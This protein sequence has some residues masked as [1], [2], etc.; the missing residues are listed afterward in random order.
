MII[1]AIPILTIDVFGSLL[2][3]VISLFALHKAKMLRK[4]DPLNF[5]YLYLVWICVGFV[6]FAVSRSSGHVLKQMLGL[7]HSHSDWVKICP[8]TGTINTVT[9]MLVGMITLFLSRAGISTSGSAT[10]AK[11]LKML[12]QSFWI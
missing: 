11:S 5:V 3:M 2:V 8:F 6:V 1:S 7:L 10:V 4:Q 12:M 9:F